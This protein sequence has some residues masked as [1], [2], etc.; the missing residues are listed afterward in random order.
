ME[1][2]VNSEMAYLIKG[3]RSTN[4]KS[5]SITFSMGEKMTNDRPGNTNNGMASTNLLRLS[6]SQLKLPKYRSEVYP[7]ILTEFSRL[8][9]D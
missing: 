3:K 7:P 5:Q 9:T 6:H 1:A 2:E 4:V 8:I